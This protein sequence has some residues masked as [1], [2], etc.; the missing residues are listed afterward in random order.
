MQEQLP[1]HEEHEVLLSVSSCS[2]CLRG[3]KFLLTNE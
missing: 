2:S 3:E 1:K